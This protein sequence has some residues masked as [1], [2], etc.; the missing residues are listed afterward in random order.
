MLETKTI[1]KIFI[2]NEYDEI[3]V[4]HRSAYPAHPEKSYKPDIPGGHVDPGEIEHAAVVRELLEETGLVIPAHDARLSYAATEAYGG[5]HPASI[6]RLLY[7]AYIAGRPDVAL[8]YEHEA[9]FWVPKNEVL[10]SHPLGKFYAEGLQ[11]L[12]DHQLI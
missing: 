5:T 10:A 8:S 9:Y 2:V 11:Y 1:T 3:L 4:L 7:V 6:T 12:L